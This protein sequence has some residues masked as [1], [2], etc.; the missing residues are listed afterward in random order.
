MNIHRNLQGLFGKMCFLTLTTEFFHQ[1][2]SK[3]E[4]F[5][6]QDDD[7]G[8]NLKGL[9]DVEATNFACVFAMKWT[10]DLVAAI[11]QLCAVFEKNAKK[12]IFM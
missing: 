10:R 3:N 9:W 7:C 5:S 11:S 2:S 8:A 4:L 6:P 12:Y 1:K